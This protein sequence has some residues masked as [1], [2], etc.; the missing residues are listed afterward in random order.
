MLSVIDTLVLCLFPYLLYLN[1]ALRVLHIDTMT[2]RDPQKYIVG[3][4]D[5]PYFFNA[6]HA[7]EKVLKE[8]KATTVHRRV[9]EA[10][11]IE[12]L[13]EDLQATLQTRVA[14]VIHQVCEEFKATLPQILADAIQTTVPSA[15]RANHD[16]PTVSQDRKDPPLVVTDCSDTE[17][18]DS[19]SSHE[20]VLPLHHNRERDHH[21]HWD[22]SDFIISIPEFH[23][24]SSSAEDFLD[25]LVAVEE[26]LD[27][28]RVPEE[29]RV[30]LVATS[31]RGCA[32]AWWNR[33][34]LKRSRTFG[35]EKLDSWDK[36]KKHMKRVF[37]PDNYNRL[38]SRKFNSIRQGPRT[39]DEYA[40]EFFQLRS[41][42]EDIHESE[43]Q[44]VARFIAGLEPR[45]QK[46]VNQFNPATVTEAHQRAVVLE[47]QTR[48]GSSIWDFWYH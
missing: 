12:K 37:L 27:F 23:G 48:G 41:R 35:K 34:K 11:A 42:I 40:T 7:S 14:D 45:L 17:S 21:N 33:F 4:R 39:V 1:S 22:S 46:M 24:V 16:V 9:A 43:R 30:S 38:L 18:E 20:D 13:C 25:W 32:A 19:L 10:A 36:L 2:S 29:H 3:D 31:F 6:D 5:W 8:C 28:K 15:N 44:L 47:Q 26:I